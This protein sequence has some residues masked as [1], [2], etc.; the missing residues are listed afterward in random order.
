[1][2]TP[3]NER[4]RRRGGCNEETFSLKMDLDYEEPELGNWSTIKVLKNAQKDQK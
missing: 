4:M 1:M 3:T 2:I